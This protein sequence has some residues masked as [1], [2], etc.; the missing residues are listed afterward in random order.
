MFAFFHKFFRK[1]S[2]CEGPSECAVVKCRDQGFEGIRVIERNKKILSLMR[3]MHSSISDSQE[4]NI[5]FI[6]AC[7]TCPPGYPTK[8]F[9]CLDTVT[10]ENNKEFFSFL[11]PQRVIGYTK[12]RMGGEH[13]GGYVLINPLSLQSSIAYSFGVSD[14][15]PWDIEVAELGMKVFQYDGTIDIPP[16][17]HENIYFQKNNICA[18]EIPEEGLKNLEQILEDHGHKQENNITLQIDIEG[19]EWEFFE[20]IKTEQIEKFSQIIV[21]FH[22][23]SPLDVIDFQKKLNI[24]KKILITHEVIHL[25]SNNF[26][27]YFFFDDFSFCPELLEVTFLRRDRHIKFE[28]LMLPD[29]SL[30]SPNQTELPDPLFIF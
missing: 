28:P 17:T 15:S 6:D 18:D 29:S 1:V 21:E 19:A 7:F 22:A 9:F 25:H 4:K 13:D 11:R 27:D 24:I 26:C 14:Y 8:I 12:T 23:L 3:S 20:K 16:N 5:D 30:D 10:H 2:S